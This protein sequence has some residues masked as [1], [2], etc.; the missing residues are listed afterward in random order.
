MKH[1]EFELRIGEKV[2]STGDGVSLITS[3]CGMG[4]PVDSMTAVMSREASYRFKPL[5]EAELKL[6]YDGSLEKIMVGNVKRVDVRL[7]SVLISIDGIGSKLLRKGSNTV[8]LS[9]TSGGIVVTLAQEAGVDVKE[10]EHG[11][12]YPYYAIDDRSNL[13]EHIVRL[14]SLCGADTFFDK[15]GKII[16]RRPGGGK[17]HMLAYGKDLLE[18]CAIRTGPSYKG[19]LVFGESPVSSKG[20]DTYHWIAKEEIKA[21]KGGEGGLAVKETSLKSSESVEK[22]G[23]ALLEASKYTLMLNLKTEGKPVIRVGDTIKL[24]GF[25]DR[26]IDG[27]HEVTRVEHTLSALRGFTSTFTCRRKLE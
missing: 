27:S 25:D 11:I 9:H 10:F 20:T 13:F 23:E 22:A 17:E 6:G 5:E 16:F 1:P 24:E 2:F 19:V 14:G 7:N 26:E 8:F 4:L 3:S 18:V 21:S 12:S 15:D